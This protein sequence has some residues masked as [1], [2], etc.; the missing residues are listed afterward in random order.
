MY[1][2][3]SDLRHLH[4]LLYETAS[5]LNEEGCI[6]LDQDFD[7]YREMGVKPAHAHKSK[8]EHRKALQVLSSTI[9]ESLSEQDYSEPEMM[10]EE[11]P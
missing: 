11:K 9:V 3:R 10:L 6:D 5:Y 2:K 8:P 1:F 7:E 4:D